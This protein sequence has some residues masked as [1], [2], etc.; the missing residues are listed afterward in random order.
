MH[1]IISLYTKPT[2]LLLFSTVAISATAQ[3]VFKGRITDE[4]HQPVAFAN[5]V[6][7]NPT[8]STFIEG[9]VSKAD[10][11][12]TLTA[13]PSAR[14][15][16]LLKVSSTGYKTDY[17][18]IQ[19]P[20][21][22]GTIELKSDVIRLKGATVTAQRPAYS[23][24]N[25]GITANVENSVLSRETSTNDVLRKLPGM[26]EKDGQVQTFTGDVPTIYINGKKATDY[27]LVKNLPVKEIK[28]VKLLTNPGAE[29]D[30]TT[31][32]VLLISTKKRLE[33]LSVQADLEG[34]R[35]HYNSHNEGL[36]LS[37]TAGKVSIF[38]NGTYDDT[39]SKS[40]END[41]ISNSLSTETYQNILKSTSKYK[42]RTATYSLGFNYDINEKNHW[43][44]E[45]SGSTGQEKGNGYMNDST[46]LNGRLY[47]QVLSTS[48]SKQHDNTNHINAFYIGTFSPK[49]SFKLY[50]DY[51]HSNTDNHQ[52]VEENSTATAE[53]T[54]ETNSMAKYDI[55]AAKGIFSYTFTPAQSLNIGSEYSYTDG[56]TTLR[57]TDG[58]Y[59]SDYGNIERKIAGFAEYNFRK[60][61]FALTAGLRYEY[62]NSNLTNHLDDTQSLHRNYSNLLPSLSINYMTTRQINHGLSFRSSVSRPDF[63]WMSGTSNY[64]NR[65]MR[66]LGNP[67]LQPWTSYMV[68]YTFLYKTF[69]FQA[70]YNY[71]KDYMGFAPMTDEQSPAVILATMKNFNHDQM[72]N[73]MAA[74]HYRWG[75]YQPSITAALYKDFFKTEYL[76]QPTASNKPIIQIDWNNGFNLPGDFFFNAEYRYMSGGGAQFVQL[77]PTHTLNLSLQKSLLKD[78]L[79][80]TLKGNDL[81]NKSRQR[82]KGGIGTVY[83]SQEQFWDQRSVSLHVTYRFNSQNKKTY[84]GQSAAESEVQ[85]LK[86]K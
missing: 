17:R 36:N 31:K 86:T 75:F 63:Q 24:E 6:L 52:I 59:P 71:I 20:G 29:Y 82:M 32:C 25:G 61:R 54:V 79:T 78:K 81:L 53:R 10:G 35:N 21:N 68:Q 58:S 45:Y 74:Y 23:L 15:N 26:M 16:Y 33:G 50:T 48:H 72:L 7:L 43:G 76:G 85:R 14:G 60:N 44:V 19:Q 12:F 56:S 39:R 73:F 46:F 37:Y 62:V 47:D 42:N 40:W 55:Y 77:R 80:F 65:Y 67:K 4:R 70:G 83:I 49:A 11:S 8:D 38:A 51:L 9:A 3:V 2:A 84:K 22:I 1:N 66:Q 18:T 41:N 34:R 64:V 27:S 69:M 5:A 30:A 13:S 28:H 57:Y